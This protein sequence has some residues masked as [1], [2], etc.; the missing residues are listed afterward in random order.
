MIKK[1]F[2]FKTINS[3]HI[4]EKSN[5]CQEKNNVIVLKV[6]KNSTKKEI[7]IAVFKMFNLLVKKVNLV[8][9]KGKSKKKGKNITKKK[10][11]K[12][13]YIFLKK[14]QNLDFLKL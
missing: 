12:K 13:A 5:Q 2:L 14:N 9:I 10:T 11:I 7:K 4:S 6:N 8:N 1:N 3:L